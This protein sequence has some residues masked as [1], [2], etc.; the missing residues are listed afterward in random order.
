MY[1]YDKQF[2]G[3]QDRREEQPLIL[4]PTDRYHHHHRTP[5]IRGGSSEGLGQP[6]LPS[7]YGTPCIQDD[8]SKWL[9]FAVLNKIIPK[10]LNEFNFRDPNLRTW[11][12]TWIKLQFVPAINASWNTSNPIRRII[13][14][15]HTDEVGKQSDNYQ[16][17][18]A[19]ANAVAEEIKKGI[20]PNLS[21]KIKFETFSSGECQPEIRAYKTDPGGRLTRVRPE[22]EK[23]NRRV[24][25]YAAK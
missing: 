24:D 1:I 22:R 20:G 15:G 5:D 8:S 11:H 23:R 19:R 18:K 9:D 4:Q 17:G 14:V 7:R 12:K 10:I 21:S 6:M 3:P 2:T 16:L 25:V 13:L